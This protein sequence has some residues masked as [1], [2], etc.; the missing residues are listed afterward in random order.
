MRLVYIVAMASGIVGKNYFLRYFIPSRRA[1]GTAIKF[2][3]FCTFGAGDGHARAVSYASRIGYSMAQA[4]IKLETF[5]STDP[6]PEWLNQLQVT[7]SMGIRYEQKGDV[8]NAA[9]CY[10]TVLYY[11]PRDTGVRVRLSKCYQRLLQPG[12]A[13]KHQRLAV[14]ID[15]ASFRTTENQASVDFESGRYESCLIA[16]NSYSKTYKTSSACNRGLI[17]VSRTYLKKNLT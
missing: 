15:P 9:K 7:T 11:D 12:N 4:N 5:A 10:E 14:E 2:R 16:Y 8:E 13:V 17:K 1:R 3:P 6:R